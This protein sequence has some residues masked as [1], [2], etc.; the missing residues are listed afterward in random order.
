MFELPDQLTAMGGKESD[1]ISAS[2][3]DLKNGLYC[4]LNH[5][6]PICHN[7][8][9]LYY[10]CHVMPLFAFTASGSFGGYIIVSRIH[11]SQSS[12]EVK[13][14]SEKSK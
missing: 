9:T 6:N 11:E 2:S 4:I 13:T 8:L 3:Y 1:V 10:V 14:N 12:T 7:I 5:H